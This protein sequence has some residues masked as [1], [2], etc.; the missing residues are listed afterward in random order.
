MSGTGWGALVRAGARLPS[1]ATKQ[2]AVTVPAAVASLHVCTSSKKQNPTKKEVTIR[3]TWLLFGCCS[4]EE[5]RCEPAESCFVFLNLFAS[6]SAREPAS[7]IF[8]PIS[9]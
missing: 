5:E 2:P 3:Q 7:L 4:G 6:G 9:C 1:G 8:V